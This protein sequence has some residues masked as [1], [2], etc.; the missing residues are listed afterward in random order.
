MATVTQEY[1]LWIN[2]EFAEASSETRELTEPATGEPL[3]TVAMASEADVDRA[4]DAAQAALNGDWA[5]TPPNERSRLLHA[6]ADALVANRKE[7]AELEV[8]NVGKALSSVK[9]ELAQAV[10]NYR[11]YASAIATIAG[12][13]NPPCR[14][15]CGGCRMRP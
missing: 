2:G 4:V 12:R 15:W 7:L 11:F 3:A 6:L 8:R 14:S 9:A 5:K 13:S 1:G 10:E